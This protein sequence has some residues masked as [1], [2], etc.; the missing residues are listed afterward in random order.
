MQH[1]TKEN[2]MTEAGTAA[3]RVAAEAHE[4]AALAS[5]AAAQAP[6]DEAL[7]ALEIQMAEE[8]QTASAV[9]LEQAPNEDAANAAQ[10]AA[11]APA[12]SPRHPNEAAETSERAAAAHRKASRKDSQMNSESE[13]RFEGLVEDMKIA[14]AC[15][16]DDEPVWCSADPE[17]ALMECVGCA[18]GT[19]ENFASFVAADPALAGR[20]VDLDGTS[21]TSLEHVAW[22]LVYREVLKR[23]QAFVA[24]KR[25]ALAE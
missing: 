15:F 8:A 4:D 23:V 2:E 11:D 21:Q 17:G 18:L 19:H 7:Q 20:D 13:K 5:R 6:A 3:H 25:M 10:E 1:K 16:Q 24:A 22:S 9:A 12:A 14:W